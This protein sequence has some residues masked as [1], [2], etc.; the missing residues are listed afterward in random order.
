MGTTGWLKDWAVGVR[1]WIDRRGHTVLG[2]GRAELLEA[3]G[4]Q[5]SITAAAKAVGMSYR[6]AWMLVQAVNEAAGES[7]VEAA[8]GGAQG[9][10][11]RLT[12]RG[13]YALDVYR[14][15]ERAMGEASARKLSELVG[16]GPEP[17]PAACIHVAA[18]ISFQNA[19]GQ[20]LAAYAL[21]RPL[22]RI[23][24]IYGASNELASQLLA[25]APCDL[26]ISAEAGEIDRLESAARVR[27]GTRRVVA[28]NGL[29]IIGASGSVSIRS[30]QT[31][32]SHAVR[33]IAIAEQS[34]PLGRYT[35]AQL[36]DADAYE[37]LLA[38]SLLVDDSQGVIS[39]VASGAADCGIA[40][41]SAAWVARPACDILLQL[42][43]AKNAARYVAAALS[44]GDS[45]DATQ[46]LLDFISS[47]TA[48][49]CL[50]RCGFRPPP[51]RRTRVNVR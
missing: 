39:A 25:G 29:S 7:L 20:I 42:P 19:L 22:V 46:E 21:H 38:K 41:T 12:D 1:L 31:L 27:P 14:Q 2:Q 28:L 6:K 8:V 30:L 36:D 48:L 44:G 4:Q 13:R 16:Q 17:A 33:R 47:T 49:R 11:A 45:K 23:R 34:C 24:T 35:K 26:F 5:R 37:S 40:F 50:R 18:A 9:G 10:G 3:I 51:P 43:R 15:V 32:Q